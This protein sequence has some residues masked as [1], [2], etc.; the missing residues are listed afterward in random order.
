[1]IPVDLKPT[2]EESGILTA[3]PITAPPSEVKKTV[4]NSS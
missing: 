4:S 1:M 2:G 3:P